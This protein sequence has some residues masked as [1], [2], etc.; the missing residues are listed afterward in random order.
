[1]AHKP[2]LMDAKRSQHRQNLILCVSAEID[3]IHPVLWIEMY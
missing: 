3:R 2:A 1:M